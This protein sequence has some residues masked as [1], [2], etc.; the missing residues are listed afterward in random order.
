MASF[1]RV[2]VLVDWDTARRLA[3]TRAITV[4]SIE[5]VFEKL[6][7]GIS[8]YIRAKD[9]KN[10]YR[11]SWRIYH[12]WHRG[13]TKTADR[14]LFE[15]YVLSSTSRTIEN[16]S[17]ST[18][19]E[20]SGTLSCNTHRGP[21]YDTLR[22]DRQTGEMRQ[23]MVDTMLVCD[24]LHLVRERDSALLIIVGDDDDFAPALVTAEAWRAIV[25]ML[26]IRGDMN[27]LLDLRG[28]AER[29]DAA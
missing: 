17:F 9:R 21:I 3:P 28:L 20:F 19:F 7:T 18:N 12:G 1:H 10:I 16:V 22:V 23:K 14:R 4:R 8:R 6:Q 13:L 15:T 11:V 5:N 24:L 29:L 26:H 2:T 25:V 27:A